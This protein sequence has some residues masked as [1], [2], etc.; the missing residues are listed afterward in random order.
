VAHAQHSVTVPRPIREVYGFLADGLNDPKWR[1]DVIEV[2][3]ESGTASSLDAVYAQTMKGPG[4]RNIQ[5]DYRITVAE[6]PTRLH[7]E[8]IAGPAHPT[9]RFELTQLSPTQPRSRSR[10]IS[11]R[12]G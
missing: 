4:G 9:G 3:L 6:E 12:G 8:V 10:S 1:P 5:G 2:H 7:F 11:S